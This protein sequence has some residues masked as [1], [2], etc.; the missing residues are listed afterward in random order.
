MK[1]LGRDLGVC[2]ATSFVWDLEGRFSKW[3]FTCPVPESHPGRA[4]LGIMCDRQVREARGDPNEGQSLCVNQKEH[5]GITNK[6]RKDQTQGCVEESA[7]WFVTLSAK[8]TSPVMKAEVSP[9]CGTSKSLLLIIVM[10]HNKI[11]CAILLYGG[12]FM[13]DRISNSTT[14]FS[15]NS[16]NLQTL[17]W[18][19]IY[20]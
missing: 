2:S 11:R 13:E 9:H 8:F 19:W 17:H 18:Q 20:C 14:N 4:E 12:T 16:L 3:H 1:T 7:E 6:K 15:L 5:L 10:Q